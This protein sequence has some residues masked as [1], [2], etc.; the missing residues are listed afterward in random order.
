MSYSTFGYSE[1]TLSKSTI[2]P[3]DVLTISVTITN[4][5]ID[6]KEA[7]LLYVTDDYRSV[8]PEVRLLKRF[9]K[10]MIGSGQCET[11]SFTL[12]IEDLIF[13]GLDDTATVEDGTFTIQVGNL[14]SGFTLEDSASYLTSTSEANDIKAP[15]PS[16][17]Y[18]LP[19]ACVS[20]F[21]LGIV[22]ATVA[23]RV[24]TVSPWKQEHQP[25]L[26]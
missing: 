11:V 1:L 6:G 14:K 19:L 3:D 2:T 18:V 23:R 16:S 13:Y 15:S 21:V 25:L 7:V 8:T 10:V 12:T 4:T 24:S 22:V 9:Q 20:T 26:V 5:G 17:Q